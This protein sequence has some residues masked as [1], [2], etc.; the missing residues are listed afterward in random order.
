MWDNL[1]GTSFLPHWYIVL[2]S[3]VPRSYLVGSYTFLH[4][5]EQCD[6]VKV[7]LQGRSTFTRVLLKEL[8]LC[9]K[10]GGD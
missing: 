2:T 1:F 8:K 6:H 10:C 5:N 7:E 9:L 3:L 4:S